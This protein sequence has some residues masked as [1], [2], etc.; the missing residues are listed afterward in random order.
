MT[1]AVPDAGTVAGAVNRPAVDTVPAV[2]VQLTA[3]FEVPVTV[4]VSVSVAP[5]TTVA[6][7]GL[8]TTLIGTVTVT[9]ELPFA[10]ALT[11]LV[12]VIVKLCD[13]TRLAGA[14]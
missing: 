7:C 3:V 10:A 13:I 5:V 9:V 6:T 11:T 4:A 2:V 12:A 1:V 8:T 14:V